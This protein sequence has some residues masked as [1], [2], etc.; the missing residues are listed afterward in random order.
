L[1]DLW[2]VA[3][4]LRRVEDMEK[5][6]RT[7]TTKAVQ[8]RLSLGETIGHTPAAGTRSQG[9]TNGPD[10]DEEHAEDG[11]SVQ[12][13]SGGGSRALTHGAQEL[14]E[15]FERLS[16]MDV[17]GMMPKQSKVGPRSGGT[18]GSGFNVTTVVGSDGEGDMFGP[19]AV[20]E[21]I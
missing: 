12:S 16:L 3:E 5:R 10:G 20:I 21:G 4:A 6:R 1:I 2:T 15:T 18:K 9:E 17:C 19:E 13:G 11:G 8:K 14:S 7:P